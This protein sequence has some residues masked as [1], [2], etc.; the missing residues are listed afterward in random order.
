MC[1]TAVSSRGLTHFAHL[2]LHSLAIHLNFNEY[3]SRL[4]MVRLMCNYSEKPKFANNPIAH[5]VNEAKITQSGRRMHSAERQTQQGQQRLHCSGGFKFSILFKRSKWW[6]EGPVLLHLHCLDWF[7]CSH[8]LLCKAQSK[9][10]WGRLEWILGFLF[11]LRKHQAAS[12]C[13]LVI[14]E[15]L[16]SSPACLPLLD[17]SVNLEWLIAFPHFLLFLG[18][19]VLS[20]LLSFAFTRL[21]ASSP[22]CSMHSSIILS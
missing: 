9:P 16:S 6:R 4:L 7:Q 1:S 19:L 21:S 18:L 8:S 10:R 11:P 5:R 17:L 14:S 20:T 15:P 2:L 12:P 3:I 13:M 22:S